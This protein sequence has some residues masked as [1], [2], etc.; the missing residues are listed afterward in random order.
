MRQALARIAPGLF[1]FLWSTGFIGAKYGL[2]YAEPLSFLF[3]RYLLVI[4]LMAGLAFAFRAPWPRER[5]QWLHI[6]VSGLLL[7]AVYLAGVYLSIAWGL[8]SG[9]SSLIVGL[10]PLLVAVGAGLWLRE[11]VHPRQQ[12]GLALGL[13][14]T[15][16]VLSG[17]IHG[18]FTLHGV[19][20][21][22][23]GLLGI[24]AGALYQKRFCSS[25]D[26]RS[27]AVIQFIPAAITTGLA[28][29]AYETFRID[30]TMP[31]V[32][33]LGWLVLV[34]SLG[35]IGLLNYL[36]RSG[37]A[38]NV[39]SL[40]YLVPPCTAVIAWLL[41]DETLSIVGMGGMG[42]AALGVYLARK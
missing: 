36:I 8:P 28:V 35:A 12:L 11:R 13:V 34:L 21:A 32:F 4:A 20:P 25:F 6:G 14:G 24:T 5:R 30:W 42:L 41:F 17:R 38:V 18:G 29:L 40:F 15:V 39:A 3:V 26:F 16:M 1:V 2:P 22:V 33:S 27:G 31:F 19:L 10:Q 37:T 7:H 9:V 23:F